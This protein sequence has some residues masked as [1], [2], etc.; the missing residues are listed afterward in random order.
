MILHHIWSH[1]RFHPLLVYANTE[2]LW[3]KRLVPE[4]M[5][6]TDNE[7][8]LRIQ[9][10][11]LRLLHS[12]VSKVIALPAAITYAFQIVGRKKQYSFI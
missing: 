7:H 10:M 9:T 2:V 4:I 1:I 6:S 11:A 12:P 8:Q 3:Y 5:L